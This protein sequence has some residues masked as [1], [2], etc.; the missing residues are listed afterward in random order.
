MQFKKKQIGS[1]SPSLEKKSHPPFWKRLKNYNDLIIKTKKETDNLIFH[2]YKIMIVE[3][4]IS[5]SLLV[6]NR[7]YNIKTF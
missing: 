3:I 6:T 2:N 4:V 5:F 1:F 7:H